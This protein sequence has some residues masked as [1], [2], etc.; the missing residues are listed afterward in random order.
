MKL[1]GDEGRFYNLRSIMVFSMSGIAH[2]IDVYK[3]RVLVTVVPSTRYVLRKKNVLAFKRR[4]GTDIKKRKGNMNLTLQAICDFMTWSLEVMSTGLWP[5]TAFVQSSVVVLR[6][7]CYFLKLSL[8]TRIVFVFVYELVGAC[9][10]CGWIIAN[11][12]S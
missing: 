5:E 11:L 1:H 4:D 2:D 12:V 9:C 8:A 3:T 7:I 6:C 10:P